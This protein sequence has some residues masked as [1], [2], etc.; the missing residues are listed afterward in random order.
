MTGKRL[1]LLLCCNSAFGVANFRAGLLKSWCEAGHDVVVVAPP[2]GRFDAE[3]RSAG[4]RF[5][6][7]SVSA[8]SARP[9]TEWVALRQLVRIYREAKPDLAFHYTIKPVVYGA[10][11][12]SWTGVPCVSVITGLGYVFLNDGAVSRLARL[13]YRLTLQRSREVWF[14][15]EDDRATFKELSLLG[16]QPTITLPGEGIDLA[17]FDARPLPPRDSPAGKKFV[18]L[19]VSRLLGD[20]GVR[21]YVAAARHLRM[22]RPDLVF[23]LLGPIDNGNPTAIHRAELDAWTADGS[24]EYLGVMHDVRPAVHAAHA[25]VL[26]S[27]GEGLPRTLLEA[28][29]MGRP[30]VATNVSGCRDVVVDRVTGLLCRPRDSRDLA[31]RLADLADFDDATLTRMAEA[32]RAHVAARF[33]ERLILQLYADAVERI[34]RRKDGALPVNAPSKS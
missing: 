12:A 34:A 33:D 32:A 23:R 1:T 10:I 13:L 18:F 19:M 8:R 31:G 30:T 27:Y 24:I 21:E 5:L 9:S 26:P 11:A 3:I 25:V 14:L 29:A 7:W 15:N 2:D 16:A 17:R 20:K 4:A 28:A 22:S 6:P